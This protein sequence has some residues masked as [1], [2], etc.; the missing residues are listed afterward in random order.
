MASGTPAI[1]TDAPAHNEHTC[2]FPVKTRL[3]GTIPI[4]KSV[5]YKFLPYDYYNYEIED[6]DELRETIDYAVMHYSE[7]S[8]NA[9]EMAREYNVKNMIEGLIELLSTR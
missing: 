8:G 7:Y 5:I 2:C 9:V 4:G 3:A 6:F 1:Y